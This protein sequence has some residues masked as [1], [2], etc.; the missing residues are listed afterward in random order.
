MTQS[1]YTHRNL[2]NNKYKS[3]WNVL[4]LYKSA[5]INTNQHINHTIRINPLNQQESTN[6]ITNH[7][8]TY[9]QSIQ[10]QH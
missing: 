7:P 9:S 6:S 5:N 8:K 4:N 10:N 3:T 1:T 2:S